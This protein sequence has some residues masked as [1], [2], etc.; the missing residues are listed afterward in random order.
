MGPLGPFPRTEISLGAL[1]ALG[2]PCSANL[3]L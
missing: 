3:G 1:G 2:A